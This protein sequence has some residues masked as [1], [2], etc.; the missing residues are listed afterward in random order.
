M[1]DRNIP[2]DKRGIKMICRN[3]G[4]F[5]ECINHVIPCIN[6]EDGYKRVFCKIINH[7]VE[8]S[9]ETFTSLIQETIYLSDK[10]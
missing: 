10:K 7:I 4:K 6:C 2:L 9:S 3:Y 8:L 1:G 5:K